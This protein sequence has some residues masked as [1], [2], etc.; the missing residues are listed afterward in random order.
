MISESR[1]FILHPKVRMKKETAFIESSK[2]TLHALRAN[3]RYESMQ[4][5]FPNRHEAAAKRV[6]MEPELFDRGDTQESRIPFR[7]ENDLGQSFAPVNAKLRPAHRAANG[8]PVSQ[9]ESLGLPGPDSQFSEQ[10]PRHQ[11]IESTGIHFQGYRKTPAAFQRVL[12]NRGNLGYAHAFDSN[13]ITAFT[14]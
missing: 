11:G 10:G 4:E 5:E 13:R 6:N 9:L 3:L 1:S 12:E 14:V 7:P 8:L 2:V